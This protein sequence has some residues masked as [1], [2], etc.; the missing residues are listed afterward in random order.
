M[1]LS[2]TDPDPTALYLPL[3]LFTMSQG[4][5]YQVRLANALNALNH[6]HGL[7]CQCFSHHRL[8]VRPLSTICQQSTDLVVQ[9]ILKF[10]DTT[11][12]TPP[13]TNAMF[14]WRNWWH[15]HANPEHDSYESNLDLEALRSLV[16]IVNV[17]FFD[18]NLPEIMFEWQ[19]PGHGRDETSFEMGVGIKIRPLLSTGVSYT[20]RLPIHFRASAVSRR[21]AMFA[22]FA[23]IRPCVFA[24][25][26][27]HSCDMDEH[28]SQC[29]ATGLLHTCGCNSGANGTRC[30]TGSAR[31]TLAGLTTGPQL[32]FASW[33]QW[34]CGSVLRKP[35]DLEFVATFQRCWTHGL[36]MP[37]D[38]LLPLF[39]PTVRDQMQRFI[40]M[41]PGPDE[42]RVRFERD[43]D[44]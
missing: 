4:S 5:N 19:P 24:F 7:R 1:S 17:L 37:A 25:I 38:N 11:R 28:Y 15:N 16:A 39:E 9:H 13:Q 27:R 41:Y 26:H 21:M 43:N 36:G 33:I 31:N 12:L 10:V 32:L 20:V 6:R 23:V 34:F 42:G 35:I 18:S 44:D 14:Q 29:T 22:S 3:H 2:T 40:H 30:T 8:N